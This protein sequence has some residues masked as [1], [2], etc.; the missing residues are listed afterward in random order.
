MIML[1]LNA[2]GMLVADHFRR[3]LN[4]R[5]SL[6]KGQRFS[7]QPPRL[8]YKISWLTQCTH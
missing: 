2:D 1:K 4:G 3:S 7:P 8:P 5:A 6:Q